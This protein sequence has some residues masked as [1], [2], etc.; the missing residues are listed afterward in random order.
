[1]ASTDYSGELTIS[2]EILKR[3]VDGYRRIRNT[4]R[5]LLANTAD[6]D[7]AKDMLPVAEWLE[8]DRY[9]LAMTRQMQ[10]D[11]EADFGRYEFHRVVQAL[12]TFCSEDLGG[13]YLD[14]L[15]D[16]LYTTKVDSRARR[17]A[18]SAL[19]HITQAF[20]KLMA[21]I[22]SFTAEEVWL[23]LSGDAEESVMLE[24]WQPL[25]AQTDESELVAK[26]A[27]IRNVRGEV[28][29][30]L[31][32]LRIEGKI[33]APLQADLL[34]H[35]DGEKFDALASLGDDL[36]Y[37]F[38]VSSARV[39]KSTEE[40]VVATPLTHAKCERCWHVR[41]DVGADA[42]HPDLCGRCV[43]NLFGEGEARG[44]A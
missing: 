25:P 16:R 6:F 35:V 39:I 44:L 14:I 2:D 19:W 33:G 41:E 24:T 18:Q 43:S 29:K 38:I 21:P 5:F 40:K 3:A 7:A 27:L 9:A 23:L 13:F 31:E 1:V 36:K 42:D 37:V 8:I 17:S 32:D 30:A 26:W 20:V 15:K 34:L 4:L 22:L 10:Q 28:T 12:Q 11:A